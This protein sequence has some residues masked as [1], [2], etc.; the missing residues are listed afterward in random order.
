MKCAWQPLLSILPQ[1]LRLLVDKTG[2]KDLLELRLRLGKP[3]MFVFPNRQQEDHRPVTE[4]ELSFIVNTASRYSPW[5]SYTSAQGYIT[6]P[7][8]HRIGLCGEAVVDGGSMTG[9]RRVRSLNLRI[10]RDLPGCSGQLWKQT[11][12]VLIIG[13]PGSGKTTLLR[14]LIRQRSARENVAVVDQRGELF[15]MEADFDTGSHTD[16]L[17]GCDKATGVENVIRTMTPDT[18][19]LDE[20]TG[21]ADLL[22]LLR[23]GHCGVDLLATAHASSAQDLLNRPQYRQIVLSKLFQ[24]LVLLQPDKTWHVERMVSCT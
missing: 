11:G 23:A 8:G 20:I 15:P 22:A 12:S 4:Q 24:H 9:L 5:L 3:A 13:K 19:A 18:V 6:A 10:A 21:E 2:Q 14:D 7:G 17:T 16:I 1:R